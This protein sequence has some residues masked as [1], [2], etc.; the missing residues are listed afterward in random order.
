MILR[1]LGLCL[2][3]TVAIV[4]SYELGFAQGWGS[5]QNCGAFGKANHCQPVI[6]TLLKPAFADKTNRLTR[7]AGSGGRTQ[8]N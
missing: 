4:A 7:A 6:V 5:Y 8:S 3:T 1:T 2:A